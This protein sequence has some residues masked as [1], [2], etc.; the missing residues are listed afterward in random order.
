ML[1]TAIALTSTKFDGVFDKGGHPYILH[2]LYV[3]YGVD[4]KDS[5]LMQIAVLHD[6]IEDTDITIVDLTAMGFSKRVTDALVCLTHLPGERYDVYINRIA[7]NLD[8]IKVKLA[9]LQH[10]SDINRMKGLRAKDFA[11][12]GK[13]HKS[14][15]FLSQCLT[16]KINDRFIPFVLD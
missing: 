9:D 7:F 5:E 6:V 16:R 10:N 1:G 13:Y 2:C 12:L 4:Q 3:M 8:A 14:H 11:R 15:A